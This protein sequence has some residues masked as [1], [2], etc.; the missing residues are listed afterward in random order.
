MFIK[1]GYSMHEGAPYYGV[2]IHHDPTFANSNLFLSS[3]LNKK[4]IFV[5]NGMTMKYIQNP[6]R[7]QPP[8][9]PPTPKPENRK[10]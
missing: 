6:F 4:K 5:G 3:S 10:L 7:S 8:P 2:I 1:Y 9:P